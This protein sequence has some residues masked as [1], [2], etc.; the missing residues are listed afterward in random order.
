MKYTDIRHPLRKIFGVSLIKAIFALVSVICF[1]L[2]AALETRKEY[3]GIISL[4]ICFLIVTIFVNFRKHLWG[5]GGLIVWAM[6]FLRHTIFPVI[7][8]LGGY[9]TDAAVTAY[10]QY[11]NTACFLMDIELIVVAFVFCVLSSYLLRKERRTKAIQPLVITQRGMSRGKKLL[12]A[13]CAIFL[14]FNICVY[15]MYPS[16]FSLYWRFIFFEGDKVARL[17][18]LNELIAVIPG[19]IYYPFKLTSEFLKMAIVLGLVVEITNSKLK[20]VVK[21]LL[22][23]VLAVIAIGLMSSEQ[24][25]AIILC[26]TI[27]IYMLYK[28]FRYNK[29]I[30]ILGFVAIVI[31]FVVIIEKIADVSDIEG[32][33]R[34]INNYFDGP[35]NIAY[36]IG[37]KNEV[38]P[39][40]IHLITDLINEIP[41]LEKLTEI[42]STNEIFNEFYNFHGAVTP[43]VGYGY[44]YFGYFGAAL[45]AVIVVVTVLLLDRAIDNFVSEERKTIFLYLTVHMAMAVGMYNIMIYYSLWVYEIALPL[46]LVL[47]SNAISGKKKVY[48]GI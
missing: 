15:L 2:L 24:I 37:L 32:L 17:N 8:V 22:D 20:T 33:A 42:S 16:L 30:V 14:I 10:I 6:Y 31:G 3:L 46:I 44:I 18:A 12:I 28:Y 27:F 47:I 45:P 19:Y 38:D 26:F 5:I 34:I 4:P 13:V 43:M 35:I 9:R 40:K 39:G 23:G 29:I 41:I 11:F 36:S 48:R 1:I 7:I 21:L 25:N